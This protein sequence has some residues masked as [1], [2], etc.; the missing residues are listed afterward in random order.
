LLLLDT[1]ISLTTVA[2]AY[3]LHNLKRE[4]TREVTDAAG[5][6]HVVTHSGTLRLEIDDKLC[7]E[8]YA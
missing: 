6:T 8:S 3:M 5:G 1:G 4:E 7:V 2:P